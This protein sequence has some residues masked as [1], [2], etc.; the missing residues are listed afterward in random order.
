MKTERR[1]ELQQNALA[2]VLT[3]WIEAVKPYSTAILGG[4]IVVL[5]LV[6]VTVYLSQQAVQQQEVAWDQVLISPEAN[7][8][9]TDEDRQRLQRDR[10]LSVADEHGNTPAGVYARLMAANGLLNSGIDHLFEDKAEG[11][12][13]LRDAI[14][15]FTQVLESGSEPIFTHQATLGL[16]RA[17]ESLNELP[18]ARKYYQQLVDQKGIYSQMAEGRLKDLDR[19]STKDFYD[20]F[21]QQQ[22]RPRAEGLPGIPGLGPEFNFDSAAP[23]VDL[24][25]SNPF[26]GKTD[27][28]KTGTESKDTTP[29]AAVESKKSEEDK[30]AESP[31]TSPAPASDEKAGKATP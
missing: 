28:G 24:N 8:A 14:A 23:P 7:P 6:G 2:D 20:W 15:N 5:V 13:Q 3:D 12:K 25:L 18:E 4:I 9:A 10:L 27:T 17:H 21:A 11:T 16:A 19:K 26:T 30:A 29:P 31:P 22:P 1:H